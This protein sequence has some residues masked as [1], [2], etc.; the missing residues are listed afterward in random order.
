MCKGFD[1]T[2]LSLDDDDRF[3]A[4][5]P[6]KGYGIDEL[7]IDSLQPRAHASASGPPQDD[8]VKHYGYD[9]EQTKVGV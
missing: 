4:V 5:A 3:P 1:V 6:N 8:D 2:R 7:A 9:T